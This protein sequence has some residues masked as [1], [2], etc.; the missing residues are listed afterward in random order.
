[1]N[2]LCNKLEFSTRLIRGLAVALLLWGGVA[3]ASE[4]TADEPIDW[5]GWDAEVFAQAKRENKFVML[6]LEAVWCHWCH[7]MAGTTYRDPRVVKLMSEHYLAVRVDQDSRPDLANRYED[8]G[9]PA[10]IIFSP[11]GEEL[12]KRRGNIPPDEMASLLQAVIDDPTPGPSARPHVVLEAATETSLGAPRRVALEKQWLSGYDDDT[13]GWGFSHKFLDWDCVELALHQAVQGDKRAAEMARVTLDKQ[14]LLIDPVWGGVYQ[15]SVGGDWVEPHYEKIMSMQAENIRIYAQAYAQWGNPA[16]LKSALSIYGYVRQFLTSPD[17]VVYTS[18]DADVVPG[19]HSAEYF[20]LN[21]ADRRAQGIPR[22]DQHIYARENGWVIRALCQLAAATG[23]KKYLQEAERAAAWVIA[24]R[25][26]PDGGFRHDEHDAA[27][28]YLGDTLAMGRAFLALHEAT[29]DSQW[30]ERATASAEYIREHFN[31]PNAVG[32]TSSDVTKGTIPTPRP[33]YEENVKLA[34]F[35]TALA[36]TTGDEQYR[37]MAGN[38]L[39]WLLAPG[40]NDD[41]FFYVAGL[42]LAEEEF[43]TEPA[44]ITVVGRRSDPVASALFAEALKVPNA[45]KLVEWWD[46]QGGP[47]PRGEAIYPEM[48]RAAAFF[49]ANG[50]CSSPM[51]TV[52]DL[53]AELA[54]SSE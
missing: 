40:R 34:R 49:C 10:T 52:E 37:T 1:M 25:A 48:D 51:F 4:S 46:P 9:W 23:E 33:Q 53:A 54:R 45:H 43:R 28:P 17:G 12:L 2:F 6:D 47:P 8:Y 18:Q 11:D 32:F 41:R 3:R 24:H 31:D 26:L 50:A 36:Y 15:Y 27:G 5:R 7:V 13:G 44:H 20:D 38:A 29:Q 42:L 19:E 21:D 30:L 39:R 22:V 14:R 16:D 35:T